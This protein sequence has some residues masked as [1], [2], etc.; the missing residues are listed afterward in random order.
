VNQR[1]SQCLKLTLVLKD[2]GAYD[3]SLRVIADLLKLIG[4]CTAGCPGYQFSHWLVGFIKNS[5]W[6]LFE[7]D[8]ILTEILGFYDLAATV[9][10]LP[11]LL[12]KNLKKRAD[13]SEI[14]GLN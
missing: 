2:R 8:I 3:E 12:I 4:D 6:R 9:D 13:F 10:L 14:G 7:S 1:D 11:F 5:I